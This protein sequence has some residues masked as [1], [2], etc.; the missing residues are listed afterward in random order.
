MFL[1]SYNL[2][3][4]HLVTGRINYLEQMYTRALSHA[5]IGY[6]QYYNELIST[7]L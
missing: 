1:S 5:A 6:C 4:K 2:L 3:M 7:N